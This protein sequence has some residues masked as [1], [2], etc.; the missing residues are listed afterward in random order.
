MGGTVSAQLVALAR[1]LWMWCLERNI[2]ITAQYLPG[3]QN[4]IADA[5][6]RTIVDRFDW[7][8]NLNL[9]RRIDH[10]FCPIEVDLFASRL[11]AQC[12]VYFSW[13]PDPYTT[14]TDAFLQ[15][16]SQ[17]ISFANSPWGLIVRVLSYWVQCGNLSHDTR[18]FWECWWITH[19]YYQGTL[20]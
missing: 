12:P 3:V 20:R 7:K 6:S 1:S 17:G 10:L 9:Y 5:E 11:T 2:H 14:A 19:V 15:D 18:S 8:L 13:R 16:W 4:T